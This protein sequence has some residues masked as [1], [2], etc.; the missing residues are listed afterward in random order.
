MVIKTVDLLKN[1]IPI[2]EESVV[3]T[4]DVKAGLVLV[5]IINGFCT[6]GAGN[7]APREPNRQISEMIDESSRLA[8]VF[9]DKKL[10][11]LAFLDSHHPDKLEYPYPSHCITGTDES[12][13]VPGT[14][15]TGLCIIPILLNVPEGTTTD[16]WMILSDEEIIAA[17]RWVEE[18]PNVTIRRKDCYDGYI[19]SFQEDGSNVFV[20]WVKN[21]QIQL[22]LVVGVCTDICVL[23]FVCSTLSAKN[24]G[25]LNPLEDVV[26]YSQG[27]ATFDFPVSMARNTKDI[28]PHPQELMHHVG[29]YMAKGRGAKIAKEVSF[30]NLN[31]P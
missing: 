27:C 12:N 14:N 22:L 20:D 23:D 28:S 2:E 3:I 26:V 17:L 11:V 10:P 30:N 9:C 5:D 29:L 19:G 21:N 24:R 7:L 16:Y 15:F 1:E 25:F 13:L 8:R 18:E 6:V 4:E 31:K